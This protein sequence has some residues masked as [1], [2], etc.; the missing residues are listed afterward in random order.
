MP[1]CTPVWTMFQ[2]VLMAA[3][4]IL[5]RLVDDSRNLKFVSG[6]LEERVN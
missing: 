5:P 4:E 2:A 3:P 1:T 6:P